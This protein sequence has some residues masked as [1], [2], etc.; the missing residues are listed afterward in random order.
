VGQTQS[1]DQTHTEHT[2]D[3]Q[4]V[5]MYE[6]KRK[7]DFRLTVRTVYVL[8]CP[9]RACVFISPHTPE[10]YATRKSKVKQKCVELVSHS[11]ARANPVLR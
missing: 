10:R 11:G 7:R 9:S 1:W 5:Q 8:L 3:A 6:R 2:K 4:P